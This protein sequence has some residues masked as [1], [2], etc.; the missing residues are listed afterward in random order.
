MWGFTL[1]NAAEVSYASPTTPTATEIHS[2]PMLAHGNRDSPFAAV[3]DLSKWATAAPLASRKSVGATVTK[4]NRSYCSK[5]RG[6][7]KPFSHHR[8]MV[9][10]PKKQRSQSCIL[11]SQQERLHRCSTIDKPIRNGPRVQRFAQ[12]RMRLVGFVV[13]IKIDL[14]VN[15]RN[16]NHWGTQQGRPRKSGAAVSGQG[17]VPICRHVWCSIENQPLQRRGIPC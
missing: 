10:E 4:S 13:S 6:H 12:R 9:E 7:S 11:C 3:D 14:R 8:L 15:P 2:T 1:L 5:R 17:G 16:N